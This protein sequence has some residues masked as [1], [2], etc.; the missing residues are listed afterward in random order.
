MKNPYLFLKFE[1]EMMKKNGG[2]VSET[3]WVCERDEWRRQWTVKNVRGKTKKF[4]KL[5]LK[6][7]TCVFWDWTKL[8]TSRQV[9]LR[10][11]LETKFLKNFLSV[12][13]DWKA[14]PRRSCEGGRENFYITSQLELP[15]ANKL[16]NR[17][18]RT[19]KPKILEKFSKSFSWLG[20]WPAS[21]S[22]KTSV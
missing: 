3:R 15:L 19:W 8:R 2:F 7:K 5:S 18:A 12:F 11:T 21:E 10:N 6:C 20:R 9:K 16:P 4:S 1:E 22:R 17:V 14:H 13:C